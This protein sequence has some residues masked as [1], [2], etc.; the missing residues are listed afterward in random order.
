MSA[1]PT[2]WLHNM[3]SS[4]DAVIRHQGEIPTGTRQ[5][6]FDLAPAHT[7]SADVPSLLSDYLSDK[8]MRTLDLEK[9][10]RQIL[11]DHAH[12]LPYP[13][14][15]LVISEGIA[16]DARAETDFLTICTVLS[17]SN[18]RIFLRDKEPNLDR[19]RLGRRVVL[20]LRSP[21]REG[22]R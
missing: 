4:P 7:R 21:E 19:V 1:I 17:K 9:K 22:S 18:S 5:V 8:G 14:A 13:S 10:V 15:A 11:R 2:S 6:M 20:L 12:A 16:E 3:S